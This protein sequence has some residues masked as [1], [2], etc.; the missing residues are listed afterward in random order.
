MNISVITLFPEIIEGYF[1]CS[2]MKRAV[3][4]GLISYRAVDL[5]LFA[6]GR[7]HRC[8]D[9]PY[10]GGAGLVMKPEPFERAL[11]SLQHNGTTA[12]VYPTP[13]GKLLT[14]EK[15]IGLAQYD[16]LVFLCGRYEG[17]DQRIIDLYVNEEISVGDYVLSSGEVASLVIIDAVYRHIDGVISGESL[18]EESFSDCALLEYPQYTRPEVFHGLRVPEIL[19]SGNHG[20]IEKWRYQKRVE[21]TLKNRPE[22]IDKK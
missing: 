13:S 11:H 6:D 21:K 1:G 20:E 9:Y 17:I 12:V 15:A 8:D 19:L 4:K 5:K 3:E 7:F 18:K 2:I 16:E 10:G 22:L 14:H